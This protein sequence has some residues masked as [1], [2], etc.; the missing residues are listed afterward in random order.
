MFLRPRKHPFAL[1]GTLIAIAVLLA[2]CGST[3]ETA[4]VKKA[5]Q[6][7]VPIITVDQHIDLSALQEEGTLASGAGAGT[8][9][10]RLLQNEKFDLSPMV[11]LLDSKTYGPYAK[12]LPVTVMK[13]KNVI[14]TKRYRNFQ[15]LDK[16]SRDERLQNL[17][18]L[19]VPEGYKKY[20]LGQDAPL[21]DRQQKMFGAVPQEADALLFVSADYAMIEDNPFWYWF[22]PISP[23]RAYIEA[24]VRMEMVDRNGNTILE[25][26]R[27]ERSNNHVNTV[28]GVTMEPSKIQPL[29]EEATKQAVAA[30]DKVT[31][32]KLAGS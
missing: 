4:N 17:N 19:L 7:A 8:L 23:D 22:L 31:K 12:R 3:L 5:D 27:T 14:Q 1:F 21:A 24:T 25:I 13:E 26:S 18:R 11:D 9:A 16:A 30:I 6:V 2:G 28:G 10:Q 20:N 29:C 15:L 32:E